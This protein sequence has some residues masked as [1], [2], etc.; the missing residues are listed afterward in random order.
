MLSSRQSHSSLSVI[1]TSRPLSSD[2][3][4]EPDWQGLLCSK[5]GIRRSAIIRNS[6]DQKPNE[7]DMGMGVRDGGVQIVFVHSLCSLP[8]SQGGRGLISIY[9]GAP[10]QE[11]SLTLTRGTLTGDRWRLRWLQLRPSPRCCLQREECMCIAYSIRS[12]KEDTT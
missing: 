2:P 6:A 7:R 3:P 12:R 4:H 10:R 11:A 5:I 8:C 1:N 9:A